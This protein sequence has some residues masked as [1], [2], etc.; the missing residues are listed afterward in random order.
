MSSSRTENPLNAWRFWLSQ[1]TRRLWWR[2]ALYGAFGIAVALLAAAFSPLVPAELAKP[3]G[4]GAVD[5]LLNVLASSLLAVATFSVAAM[6]TAYTNVSQSATPRAAALIT[7]DAG[8]QGALATFIG[9]F[10]YAVVAI[11]ALGTGYYAG[12]G[13]AIL[14][15]TTLAVLAIIAITLLRWLDQLLSLARLGHA[16][17]R[18]E[19]ATLLA[20]RGPFGAASAPENYDPPAVDAHPVPG[21]R[22]GYVQNVDVAA[23]EALAAAGGYHLWVRAAPGAFVHPGRPLALVSAPLKGAELHRLRG[24]FAIGGS[25]SFEQDPRFGMI[26]LGEIASRALS[27]AVNDPGTAIDVVGTA[28]RLLIEWQKL[29]PAGHSDAASRRVRLPRPSYAALVDDVFTPVARDGAGQLSVSVRLQKGLA[30]LHAVASPERKATLS[31][32]AALALDRSRRA[33]DQAEDLRRVEQAF[34]EG[35]AS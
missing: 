32:V 20:M 18:V 31:G 30:A 28:V 15:V 5:G 29:E 33:L 2:A 22:V 3:F 7:G 23:L 14:F 10:L 17:D 25:R 35:S 11:S 9:A 34:A 6:L 1:F 19:D 4:G 8:A 16:I 21:D 12:G 24:A 27:P 26:V 13:R